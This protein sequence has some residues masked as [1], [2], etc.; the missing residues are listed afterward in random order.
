MC[1]AVIETKVAQFQNEAGTDQL[2]NETG[3]ILVDAD[4][5][6][7]LETECERYKR[8]WHDSYSEI[9]EVKKKIADLSAELELA[10]EEIDEKQ[11]QIETLKA[12]ADGFWRQ[13]E[14]N[15]AIIEAITDAYQFCISAMAAE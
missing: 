1:D 9:E 15:E 7:Q 8:W 3:M 4:K 10:K 2:K 6:R 13:A 14:Q 12:R 11:S 5:L